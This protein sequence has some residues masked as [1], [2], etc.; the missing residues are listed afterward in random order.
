MCVYELI[1]GSTLGLLGSLCQARLGWCL[2]KLLR[3]RR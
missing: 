3:Q 1:R 2:Q